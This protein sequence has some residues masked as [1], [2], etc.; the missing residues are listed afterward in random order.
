MLNNKEWKK[1]K[2]D[3]SAFNEA[4]NV[5]QITFIGLLCTVHSIILKYRET[6]T[7]NYN[8]QWITFENIFPSSLLK[9]LLRFPPASKA[10]L[11]NTE[12]TWSW[13][14]IYTR[15]CP[16]FHY[17]MLKRY[18][19]IPKFTFLCVELSKQNQWLL[20]TLNPPL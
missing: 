9:R 13:C 4:I 16:L 8:C 11:V 15:I 5:F 3:R 17:E 18:A 1:Y 20:S 14:N 12:N 10:Y 6:Q 2:E 7:E 19:N